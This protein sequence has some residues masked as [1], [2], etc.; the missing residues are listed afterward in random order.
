MAL[1]VWQIWESMETP[2]YMS[3]SAIVSSS[4]VRR[5]VECFFP[6]LATENIMT[7]HDILHI[8]TLLEI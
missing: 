8:Y 1:V 2:R 6:D 4:T 3:V 7:L 5:S